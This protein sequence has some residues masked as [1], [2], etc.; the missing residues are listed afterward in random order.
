V[1]KND[2][3]V[4]SPRRDR[5]DGSFDVV[6][7]CDMKATPDA[8]Y[9]AWTAQIDT[10]FAAPGQIRMV[11][12]E[13]EPY[14]FDVVFNNEHHPHH[15]RLMRLHPDQLVEMTWVT[16]KNGTWGAETLVTVELKG[17]ASGTSVRLTHRGFFDEPAAKQHGEAWPQVLEHLD[18]VLASE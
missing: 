18:E 3:S 15:G 7:Q 9:K 5:A 11:A 6:L 1:T 4:V 2:N 10:W 12:Q 16:G 8:I 13:G 17:N 14:W